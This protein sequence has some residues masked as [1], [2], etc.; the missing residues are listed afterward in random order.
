[1]ARVSF[2]I[3]PAGLVFLKDRTAV[4]LRPRNDP[5]GLM[6]TVFDDGG[7]VIAACIAEFKTDFDVHFSAAID[8]P[9]A[10]TRRLLRTLFGTLF[11]RAVRITALVEPGNEH[12]QDVMRRLGF[13]YEGFIRLGIEGTR[14]AYMFGML[15]SDCRWLPGYQGGTI[16]K[17]DFAGEPHHGLVA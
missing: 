4:S 11:T 9:R 13:Q 1:L 6:C 2:D 3:E 15:R 10:I 8:D 16:R 7:T 14:D 12:G 17:T 5:W